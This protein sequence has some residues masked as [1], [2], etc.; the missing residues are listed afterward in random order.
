MMQ[1]IIIELF[2]EYHPLTETL[3]RTYSSADGVTCSSEIQ[4]TIPGIAGVDFQWIAA[5]LL[6]TVSLY[7]LFRLLGV[8]L[9]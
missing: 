4:Q 8:L 6:F 3:L 2:G 5:V 9:K 7:C 1:D